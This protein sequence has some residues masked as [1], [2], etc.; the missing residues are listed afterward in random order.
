M[1]LIQYHEIGWKWPLINDRYSYNFG[2]KIRNDEH[3]EVTFLPCWFCRVRGNPRNWPIILNWLWSTI[4]ILMSWIKKFVILF[5]AFICCDAILHTSDICKH[6]FNGQSRVIFNAVMP[7]FR[8]EGTKLLSCMKEWYELHPLCFGLWFEINCGCHPC[9]KVQSKQWR[10]W[11]FQR[12]YQQEI[13][14]SKKLSK[15]GPTT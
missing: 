13:N 3:Y 1:H 14:I 6:N 9:L 5:N 10:L 7:S 2:K 8:T 12:S 15:S 4:L 11:F